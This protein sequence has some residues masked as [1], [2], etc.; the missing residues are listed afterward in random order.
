M[1]GI[2]H[3]HHSVNVSLTIQHSG[4]EGQRGKGLTFIFLNWS[5]DHLSMVI[6][7][8]N[9]M[10]T[11]KPMGQLYSQISRSWISMSGFG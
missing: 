6:L 11:P 5:S 10:C 7:R 2:S 3:Y 9:E 4:L 8:M 1:T